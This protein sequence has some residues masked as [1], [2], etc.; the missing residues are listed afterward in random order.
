MHSVC[1]KC[2]HNIYCFFFVFHM[3][4]LQQLHE[5]QTMVAAAAAVSVEKPAVIESDVVVEQLPSPSSQQVDMDERRSLSS[6]VVETPREASAEPSSSSMVVTAKAVEE[7]LNKPK[8]TAKKDKGRRFSVKDEGI[9]IETTKINYDEDDETMLEIKASIFAF[10][11]DIIFN[12]IFTIPALRT[13]LDSMLKDPTFASKEIERVFGDFKHHFNKSEL[14]NMK[15]YVCRETTRDE[16]N[17]ILSRCFDKIMEDG[18]V[19]MSDAPHFVEL[20]YNIICMFN[21]QNKVQMFEM[22]LTRENAMNFIHYLMKCIFVLT[23]TKNEEFMAI[24][25][26]ENSFKLVDVKVM[27]LTSFKWYNWFCF[28]RYCCKK[29]IKFDNDD[30]E[31]E[32]SG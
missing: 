21:R 8:F 28:W 7:K 10:I 4:Q 30:E 31:E 24:S 19:D 2:L 14:I 23:M 3:S 9:I 12:M 15:K 26:L 5:L 27:P 29:K 11:K 13:K 25:M 20:V 16:F 32:N 17:Y 1:I 18:K 6:R 22:D